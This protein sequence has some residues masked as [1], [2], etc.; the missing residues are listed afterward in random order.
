[1]L[2]ETAKSRSLNLKSQGK[3]GSR[4]ATPSDI[5]EILS[6]KINPL[7]RLQSREVEIDDLFDAAIHWSESV[8]GHEEFAKGLSRFETEAGRVFPDE[9][10]YNERMEYF[11]NFFLFDIK[12]QN[13][14]ADF[15]Q[16]PYKSFFDFCRQLE[17]S[18]NKDALYKLEL[19]G[20]FKHSIFSIK[21]MRNDNTIM[22]KDLKSDQKF[23]VVSRH[24]KSF[25]GLKKGELIQ[26]LLFP[27]DSVFMLSSGFLIHPRKAKSFILKKFCKEKQADCITQSN[28]FKA[29]RINL[30]WVRMNTSDVS[31]V[32]R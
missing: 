23:K 30:N 13:K 20:N 22:V 9:S 21:R 12:L 24:Y 19:L 2:L 28:L 1:M 32:Y 25:L 5:S 15:K 18:I 4:L 8:F 26:G 10:F 27:W 31:R 7:D 6:E 16:T 14:K 29:A 11:L 17:F 3:L